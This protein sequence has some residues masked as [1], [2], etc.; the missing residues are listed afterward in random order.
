MRHPYLR[1]IALVVLS[2]P[3]ALVLEGVTAYRSPAV[4]IQSYLL[5]SRGHGDMTR[6]LIVSVAL[7]SAFCFAVLLGLYLLFAKLSKRD[8]K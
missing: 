3:L 2:I 4:L 5:P 1:N 6:F 8:G 7:D